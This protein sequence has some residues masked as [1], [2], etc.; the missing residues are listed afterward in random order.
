[1]N[2]ATGVSSNT[3]KKTISLAAKLREEKEISGKIFGNAI[4]KI[5]KN[6]DPEEKTNVKQRKK[7][8]S[9]TRTFIIV[10]SEI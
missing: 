10:V 1:M 8:V 7:E 6:K 2:E 4:S 3:Q 5:T 9:K